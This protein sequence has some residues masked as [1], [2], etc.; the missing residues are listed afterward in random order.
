MIQGTKEMMD[1]KKEK[2]EE[3]DLP[4]MSWEDF[5]NWLKAAL[6]KNPKIRVHRDE[7]KQQ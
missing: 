3:N 2:K 1:E 4:K 5:E 7:N 6:K